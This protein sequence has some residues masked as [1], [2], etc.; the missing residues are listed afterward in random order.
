[1]GSIKEMHQ[2]V[3]FILTDEQL[4]R[5]AS[6]ILNKSITDTTA[7]FSITEANAAQSQVVIKQLPMSSGGHRT[8]FFL[9]ESHSTTP[10]CFVPYVLG[11]PGPVVRARRW[12]KEHGVLEVDSLRIYHE[13]WNSECTGSFQVMGFK[14]ELNQ[15]DNIV[16]TIWLKQLSDSHS[17]RQVFN[18]LNIAKT[19]AEK[20]GYKLTLHPAIV[21]N[22]LMTNAFGVLGIVECYQKTP[23]S[24]EKWEDTRVV[25]RGRQWLTENRVTEKVNLIQVFV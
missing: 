25:R 23:I 4:Y 19:S 1:M 2:V 15:I 7:A 14:F 8:I 16:G 10:L 17:T 9:Q 20:L 3:G 6:D 11:R 13:K 12:L 18:T 21:N 24:V 5:I 22:M